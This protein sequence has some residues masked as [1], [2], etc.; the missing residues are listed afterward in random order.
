MIESRGGRLPFG[1]EKQSP[2][3]AGFFIAERESKGM[4]A[5]TFRR[6]PFACWISACLAFLLAEYWNT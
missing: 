2:P 4:R 3:M 1:A 6:S 5:A